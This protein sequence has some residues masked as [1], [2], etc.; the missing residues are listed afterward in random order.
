VS[1]HCLQNRG[2]HLLRK[3]GSSCELQIHRF[4]ARVIPISGIG[5]RQR[6]GGRHHAPAFDFR[7]SVSLAG[8]G[9]NNVPA[10]GTPRVRN[11]VNKKC[12]AS[13][14]RRN[15]TCSTAVSSSNSN[16]DPPILRHTADITLAGRSRGSSARPVPDAA[17]VTGSRKSATPSPMFSS[18]TAGRI[19]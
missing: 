6:S 9:G 17:N 8:T 11:G 12:M 15:C 14:G 19:R 1:R 7:V 13:K 16:G 3:I 4:A 10:C 18:R 5:D 2:V